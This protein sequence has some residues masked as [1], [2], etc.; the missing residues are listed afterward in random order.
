MAGWNTN[1][2]N[3]GSWGTGVDNIVIPTG[4]HATTPAGF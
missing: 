3:T 4:I 1:T 2:W